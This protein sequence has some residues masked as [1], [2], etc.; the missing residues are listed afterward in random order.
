MGRKHMTPRFAGQ[1]TRDAPSVPAPATRPRL[2]T[3][4]EGSDRQ[5][6]W[7]EL[8]HDLVFVVI[9]ARLA[10][11]LSGRTDLA[12]AAT[13]AA[14]FV[15]VWWAWVGETYYATRF[16]SE[17]DVTHRALA[18]LQLLGLVVMAATVGQA[19][20]AQ[21]ALFAGAYAFVRSVLVV[22]Y[23][24]VGHHVPRARPVVVLFVGAFGAGAACWWISLLLPPPLRFAFW[25]LG[26]AIEVV[27]LLGA[28]GVHARFPPHLTHLP[29]RFGLLTI[30]VLGQVVTGVV[31]GLDATAWGSRTASTALL[32]AAAAVGLWWAYFDRLDRAAVAQ[33]GTHGRT[34]IYQVWLYD[35]LPLTMSLAVAGVGMEHGIVAAG[36][37]R[38]PPEDR[39]LLLGG[40]AAYL[41]CAGVLSLTTVGAEPSRPAAR[42]MMRGRFEMAALLLAVGALWPT[43]PVLTM[44]VVAI[45]IL[46][47]VVRDQRLA[48]KRPPG[49]E[50][51]LDAPG[52]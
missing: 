36:L 5:S 24:R 28:R 43:G 21:A 15:P 26:I 39:W 23:L 27:A 35:H 41:V 2:H 6:T 49:D 47:L 9:V 1:S 29:D 51:R 40:V 12:G 34:W 20:G 22:Q 52:D 19:L 32:G 50:A 37:G 11:G 4:D 30:L 38:Y 10:E 42:P 8:F 45:A 17:K 25:A 33:L 31:R 7:F 44:A 48:G 18:S 13:F 14:L 46:V 16:D 3:V